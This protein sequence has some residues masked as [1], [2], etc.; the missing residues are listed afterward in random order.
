LANIRAQIFVI[1]FDGDVDMFYFKNNIMNT[2][3]LNVNTDRI[4]TFVADNKIIIAAVGGVLVGIT[5][6]SLAGNE[7]ARQTLRTMGSTIIDLTGK[8]VS[9]LGG[10]K[11]LIS[12]L[13]S[14]TDV[15]GV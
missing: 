11:Q 2:E 1:I 13:F 6:A 7:K 8:F 3:V 5:L 10:Y 12:P 14:K 4:K 9:D 15:Q